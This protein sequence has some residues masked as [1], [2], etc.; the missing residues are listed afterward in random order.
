MEPLKRIQKFA[1]IIPGIFIL[2]AFISEYVERFRGDKNLHWI[3]VDGKDY[4]LIMCY[5]A[6]LWSLINSIL[7]IRNLK[8]ETQK[9]VFWFLLSAATFLYMFIMMTIAMTRNVC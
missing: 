9:K 2:G 6:V 7:I 3:Y 8:I 5:G 4:S 1:I